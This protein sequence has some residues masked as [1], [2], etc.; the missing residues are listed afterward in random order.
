M[1]LIII[2]SVAEN[3]IHKEKKSYFDR[4]VSIYFKIPFM[5][6]Y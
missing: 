3:I 2:E 1:E 5:V 4:N 6:L